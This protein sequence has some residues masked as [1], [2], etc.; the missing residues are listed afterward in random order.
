VPRKSFGR[1]T[2][3]ALLLLLL[4]MT[5]F[6]AAPVMPQLVDSMQEAVSC[7]RSDRGR[8]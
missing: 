5:D 7:G 3:F 6:A 8:M 1:G 2:I 4:V